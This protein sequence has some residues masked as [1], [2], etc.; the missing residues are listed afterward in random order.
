MSKEK[1][2]TVVDDLKKIEAR[3]KK[4]L[5][6]KSLARLKELAREVLYKKAETKAL[7]DALDLSAKDKKAIV[8]W[9]NSLPS[10]KLIKEDIETIKQEAKELLEDE[11]ERVEQ[12]IMENVEKYDLTMAGTNLTDASSFTLT[13]CSDTI[14][15]SVNASVC[16]AANLLTLPDSKMS[17]SFSESVEKL[18]AV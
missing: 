1:E 12:K 10:V 3:A 17:M 7:L 9:V 2:S 16:N 8:D 15:N 6:I 11:K 14:N 4:A 13:N 18:K 5:L